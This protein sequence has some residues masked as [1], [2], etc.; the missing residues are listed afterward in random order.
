MNEEK[1]LRLPVEEWA[2]RKGHGTVEK[3]YPPR[4]KGKPLTRIVPAPNRWRFEAA[5]PMAGWIRGEEITEAEYDAAI[6]RAV[7]GTVA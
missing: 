4:G 7:N 5:K 2:Q 3:V 6:A 1:P